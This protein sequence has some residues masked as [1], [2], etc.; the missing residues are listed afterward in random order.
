VA[1]HRSEVR[2][3]RWALAD[4]YSTRP[5]SRQFEEALADFLELNDDRRLLDTEQLQFL[6]APR[7]HPRRA[8][9]GTEVTHPPSPTSPPSNQRRR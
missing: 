9:R 5:L 1:L 3:R 6:A 7:L 2:G 4:G 8:E